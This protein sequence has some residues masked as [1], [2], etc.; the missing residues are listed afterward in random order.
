MCGMHP[1]HV[2]LP[3]QDVYKTCM[4]KYRDRHQFIAFLDSDEVR[5]GIWTFAE[6][7]EHAYIFPVLLQVNT[8]CDFT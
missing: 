6:H 2:L 4:R 7:W 3:A 1:M 8:Q 5:A